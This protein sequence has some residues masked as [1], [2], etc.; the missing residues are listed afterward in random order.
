[1]KLSFTKSIFFILGAV[2]LLFSASSCTREYTCQCFISYSGKPGLPDTILKEYPITDTKKNAE[3]LCK[4]H[5]GVY[6]H[7]G[8]KTV[9][10]CR[11]W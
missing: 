1:M 4:D 2:A 3:K 5:S 8:I 7:D 10:D 6:E 11:L 9:E